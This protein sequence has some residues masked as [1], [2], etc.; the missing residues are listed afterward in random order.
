VVVLLQLVIVYFPL[1]GFEI[2]AIPVA[3]TKG[4]QKTVY[5]SMRLVIG[6]VVFIY[7]F[8]NMSL[9]GSVGS[10]VLANSP[11]PIATASGLI[12]KQS[13]SIV[14]LI[15]IVAM[16]SAINAYMLAG[17]FKGTS[18]YHFFII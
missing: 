4:G 9:I 13:Q 1:T 6:I 5:R 15:G 2:C 8:L 17:Y 3:E 12:L 11:A 18:K 10:A 7:I 14:A 16:L